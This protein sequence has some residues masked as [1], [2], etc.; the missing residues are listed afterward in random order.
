MRSWPTAALLSSCL[1]AALTT[2]ARAERPP[3]EPAPRPPPG[4]EAQG[5]PP[6]PGL[7]H[8]GIAL[9]FE[10]TIAAARATDVTSYQPIA[11]ALAYAYAA[12]LA[13]E[14]AVVK[15]R[16][17]LGFSNQL[18][19]ASVP[20]G[21]TPGTG[22]N[23]VVA[24]NPEIWARGLW[25]SRVG[26]AAG[27]GLAVVLPLPRKFSP[28]AAEVVRAV[29]EVRPWDEPH[30]QDLTL[31]ARPF[32]DIRHVVGPLTLQ[33][34]QGVDVAFHLRTP[35]EGENRVDLAALASA[36]AGVEVYAPVTLGLE[37]F[38]V[39]QLTEDVSSPSCLAPCDQHRVQFTLTPSVRLAWRHV[40]PTLSVLLPLSTPLRAEVA[41]Y[42]AARLHLGATVDLP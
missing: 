20:A 10:Y 42:Y 25:V 14:G 39:Y 40:S 16:W 30:F 19:A 5:P 31:T 6:A 8:R 32:L 18:A 29:R 34:R 36:Y 35:A 24:G 13:L 1:A 12:R 9:D 17:F 3:P 22:G 38:E 15:R 4:L 11:G 21:T 27:G 37:L 41:S 33:L 23:G 7:S 2:P 26:L 28:A